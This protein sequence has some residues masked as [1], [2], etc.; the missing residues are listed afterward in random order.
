MQNKILAGITGTFLA[1]TLFIA[2]QMSYADWGVGVHVGIGGPGPVGYYRWHDHPAWGLHIHALPVGFVTVRVG[3][4]NYYYYDGLYYNYINGDYVIV[5]P[6]AGAY[7]SAIPADFQPVII[8][9]RTY[10]ADHGIYYILTR[11]HGYKVVRAPVVVVR[12]W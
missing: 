4:T 9:G 1:L 7:V 12:T 5:N 6:P 3:W 11:H 2:P 8:R 10:Y